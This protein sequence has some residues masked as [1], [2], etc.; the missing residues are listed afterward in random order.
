M[1]I[2]N[3]C[4]NRGDF[5]N[6]EP[7]IPTNKENFKLLSDKN[8]FSNSKSFDHALFLSEIALIMSLFSNDM[9]YM[10]LNATG[11]D[12]DR[13]HF[14]TEELYKKSAEDTDTLAELAIRNNELVE[15]FTNSGN[16]VPNEV[17]LP[18]IDGMKFDENE[19]IKYLKLKGDLLLSALRRINKNY[20]SDTL[21]K[22]DEIIDYWSKE[23]EYKNNQRLNYS[24]S[25]KLKDV[26]LL[27]RNK[28]E[29]KR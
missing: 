9:K 6:K 20:P 10:H 7:L 4:K 28:R 26:I 19:F 2:L 25:D 22:I 29:N 5:N 8:N 18:L 24:R 27:R 12:F 17:Y 21:S 1:D 11:N 14:V 16:I 15:N 13:V 23:I 3:F